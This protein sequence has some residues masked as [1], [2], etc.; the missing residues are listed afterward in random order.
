[1]HVRRYTTDS[2]YVLSQIEIRIVQSVIFTE[3]LM[4]SL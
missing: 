2:K 3:Y 4:N 1:M